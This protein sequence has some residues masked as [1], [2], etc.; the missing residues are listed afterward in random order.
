M[1]LCGWAVDL[2]QVLA[3]LRSA[4]MDCGGQ[5]VMLDGIAM[6]P[7]WYADSWDTVPTQVVSV[8]H[9]DYQS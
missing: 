1:E 5:C 6:K 9:Y 2:C 8:A 7:E 3:G 4:S